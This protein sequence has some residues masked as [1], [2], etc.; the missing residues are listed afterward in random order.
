MEQNTPVSAS[1]PA[2]ET[3]KKSFFAKGELAYGAGSLGLM[4]GHLVTGYMVVFAT[5]V[6]G[7]SAKWMA[8]LLLVARV[9]DAI[10]DPLIGSCPDRW[11]IGKS[12]LRFKPYIKVFKYF[13]V[14][15]S[16]LIFVNWRPMG[17]SVGFSMFWISVMYILFGM[18]NTATTMPYNA[19]LSVVTDNP[20]ERVKFSRGKLLGSLAASLLLT[21][22]VPK[23]CYDSQNQIL[24]QR[25][26][27]MAVVL[28]I[29]CIFCFT[30]MDRRCP[31]IKTE[32][33]KTKEK[34][35]YKKAFGQIFTNRPL[36]GMMVVALG[37]AFN[38][39]AASVKPYFFAEYYENAQAMSMSA[40]VYPFYLVLMLITPIL[41]KKIGQLRI[42]RISVGLLLIL[43]FI[44]L[45]FPIQNIVL[46]VAIESACSIAIIPASVVTWTLLSSAVDFGEWKN[47][48]RG[49]GATYS[50][51][52]FAGKFGAAFGAAGVTMGLE[53]LGYVAGSNVVQSTATVQGIRWLYLGVPA[54]AA[55]VMV[56]GAF[57]LYNLSDKQIQ[58]IS[59]DLKE[60]RA[61]QAA[62]VQSET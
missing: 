47:G 4:S 14:V 8:G 42:C 45:F 52:S 54:F 17:M 24:P 60:R 2:P 50:I 36:M 44:V 43:R 25:V 16:V 55:I 34:Y 40:I 62:A 10:N 49:D 48:T 15:L 35:S 39:S 12:G 31:E 30:I 37:L 33:V 41:A 23:L 61:A 13:Y 7:I 59:H 18:A 51:Y 27:L 9:W 53:L 28:G 32:T 46:F 3:E 19:L 58:D 5:Y 20:A 26:L 57:I 11:K 22:T 29:V 21:L 56:L 1:A 6:L 38:A